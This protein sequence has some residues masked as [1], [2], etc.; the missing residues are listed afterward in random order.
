MDGGRL[1]DTE[2][3]PWLE[4][5]REPAPAP[6]P[7]SF[8]PSRP[9]GK[10]GAPLA[11]WLGAGIAVVAIAGATGYWAGRGSGPAERG[12]APVVTIP[13]A[14]V[15]PIPMPEAVV[16]E[17]AE[18]ADAPAPTVRATAPR[19]TVRQSQAATRPRASAARPPAPPATPPMPKVMAIRFSAPPSAGRAGTVVDLGRYLSPA[20]AD[21]AYRVTVARYPYLARL[22]KVVAPQRPVAGQPQ[23]YALNLG[24][25][26]ARDARI[27]CRN[28]VA[29]GRPCV[30]R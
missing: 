27:L 28:L 7:R 13:V 23:L 21:S 22:T 15:D 11:A 2:K 25:G 14:K 30:V 29:I 1:I 17:P 12:A 26:S 4:P 9:R 3:L 24:A 6:A 16:P 5:Y 8:K 19:S 20:L 10:P 18:Q